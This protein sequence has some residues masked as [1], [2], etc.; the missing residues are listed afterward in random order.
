MCFEQTDGPLFPQGAAVFHEREKDRL[1]ATSHILPG[2]AGAGVRFTPCS[3]DRRT[4]SDERPPTI[5]AAEQSARRH[6]NGL[7][8]CRHGGI[9]EQQS[10]HTKRTNH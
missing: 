5:A 9:R 8:R 3:A 1:S 6:S 7:Q 4:L 10:R 2:R